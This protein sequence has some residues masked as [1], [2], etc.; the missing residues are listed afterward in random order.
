MIKKDLEGPINTLHTRTPLAHNA[1]TMPEEQ[2]ELAAALAAL[3]GGKVPE[4][5]LEDNRSIAPT[6]EALDSS[7]PGQERPMGAPGGATDR[8]SRGP[9]PAANIPA[10]PSIPVPRAVPPAPRATAPPPGGAP[11]IAPVGV[12]RPRAATPAPPP[13]VRPSSPRPPSNRA[14]A[15]GTDMSA[16]SSGNSPQPGAGH[17]GASGVALNYS[18]P[19]PA[20]PHSPIRRGQTTNIKRTFIPIYLT[21]AVLCIVFALLRFI[22]DEDSSFRQFPL[23]FSGMM[24]LVALMLLGLAIMTMLQVKA[25][26]DRHAGQP[27]SPQG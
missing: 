3:A 24:L 20:K 9:A 27:A 18:A 26:L 6:P 23:W 21:T 4:E 16:L 17:P 22:G 14:A 2:D 19:S 11:G 10:R 1:I 12:A 25:D 8:S 15:P 13:P 5:A 7:P